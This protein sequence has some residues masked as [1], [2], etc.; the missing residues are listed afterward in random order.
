MIKIVKLWNIAN[1]TE[2]KFMT[3]NACIRKEGL[4]INEGAKYPIEEQL[5]T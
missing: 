2:G 5:Q 3:L 1:S 4:N